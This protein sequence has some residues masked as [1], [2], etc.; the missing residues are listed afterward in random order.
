MGRR[1][2]APTPTKTLKL[3]GTLRPCRRPK[4]EPSPNLGEPKIPKGISVGAKKYWADLIEDARKNGTLFECDREILLAICEAKD[5]YFT[6][7]KILSKEGMKGKGVGGA[8]AR[9]PLVG[10]LK[11]TWD[12]YVRGLREIGLSPSART[13][14]ELSGKNSTGEKTDLEK[15]FA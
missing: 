12:R 15:M 7:K 6:I 8:D 10:L 3:R 9:H 2:P 11:E 1:G 13:G 4:K 5:D 14:I